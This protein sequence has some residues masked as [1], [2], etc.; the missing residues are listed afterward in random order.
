MRAGLQDVEHKQEEHKQEAE[1]K[2]QEVDID[3]VSLNTGQEG[4]VSICGFKC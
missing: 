3:N 2:R 4:N 1:R